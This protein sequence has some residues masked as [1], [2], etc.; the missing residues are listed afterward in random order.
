MDCLEKQASTQ[1][2]AK[3]LD[4]KLQSCIKQTRGK[5]QCLKRPFR[6]AILGR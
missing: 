5:G 2:A 1:V 4:L 3:K 6:G